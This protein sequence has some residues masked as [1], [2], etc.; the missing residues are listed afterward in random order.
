MSLIK[1]LKQAL[2]KAVSPKVVQSSG[3]NMSVFASAIPEVPQIIEKK[4]TDWV[5]YGENNEYPLQLADL[6]YGSAIHNSILK[7]KT[8]MTHGEGFIIKGSKTKDES[9]AAYNSLPSNVKLDL[10]L[11]LKNPNGKDKGDILA[12]KL[13]NDLQKFGAFCYEVI[14]NIDF[15]KI[16]TLKYVPVKHVRAGKMNADNEVDTYYYS[17]DWLKYRQPGFKPMPIAAFNKNNKQSMNQLVYEKVGDLDYYGVPSYVG[18]ITWIYTDFQMGVYHSSNLENGMNPSLWLKFYKLPASE[19]DRDE[20]MA[21]VKAQFRGAKNAGKHVVTFSDGKELAPD[22]MPIETSGLDKQLLLLAELCDKKILTGHQLTSPLLAG[23]S[24]SGQLGGNTE[25][26]VAYQI[27]DKVSME[28]D[29]NFLIQS[30]QKILDFNKTPVQLDILP[31]TVFTPTG[32]NPTS[33][34]NG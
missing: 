16:V 22:I 6:P 5:L 26:Q 7:T 13:A 30:L 11:L 32:T 14:Y 23:I 17:R 19:N 12:M 18:A 2:G 4:N 29:R 10:D 25:L 28:A 21:N 1:D 8:K 15:T 27:F 24:V 9:L 31:F 20:I 33:P 34:I 3:S